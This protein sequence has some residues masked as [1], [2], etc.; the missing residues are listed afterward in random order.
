MKLWAISD[1]HVGH[2][3]NRR[4]F[5]EIPAHPEDWLIL[6]GDVG[7]TLNHLIFTLRIVTERFARVIW[8]P[9]NH[10]L[11]TVPKQEEFRGDDKYKALLEVCRHFGVLTP[12]DPYPLWPG[13]DGP[14]LIC[15]LFLLYDYSF[16][17]DGMTPAQ[18][19]EWAR[20]SG[21][22]CTDEMLLHPD[23]YPTRQAWCAARCELT[24][25]RLEEATRTHDC[26]LILI[27]HFPL[28]RDLA[29]LPRVPRF[30]IWCGTRITEDWHIR[31]RAEV[32]V[33]GHLH[34][35]K[36]QE[37]DGVRFEEVSLGYPRQRPQEREIGS[38]L[39]QILPPPADAL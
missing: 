31:F 25:R 15:P 20:E 12:E 27:N 4:A 18:A 2:P 1:T 28:R 8:V 34:I 5:T 13:P 17:P 38:F 35:R 39:R 11:W 30:S 32:V 10:E 24:E 9:G 21:I 16:C 7:E 37:R 36:Q 14:R 19:I 29:V 23:P 33:Y 6:G 26:P 3:D 22:V